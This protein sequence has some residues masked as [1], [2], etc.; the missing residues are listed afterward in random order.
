[1]ETKRPR[2]NSRTFLLSCSID[3]YKQDIYY[4]P[5]SSNSI[6]KC[7]K[8]KVACSNKIKAILLWKCFYHWDTFWNRFCEYKSLKCAK[9]SIR[10]VCTLWVRAPAYLP[11]RLM[12]GSR[13]WTC[14]S[15]YHSTIYIHMY[16]NNRWYCCH[17]LLSMLANCSATK[18]P[19]FSPKV[20]LTFHL[21]FIRQKYDGWLLQQDMPMQN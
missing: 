20:I 13:Q 15:I 7:F 16:I 4:T 10:T 1:M 19:L 18:I 3:Y 8:D 6:I 11:R 17:G 5:M 21:Q 14:Y 12:I 2:C 9:R